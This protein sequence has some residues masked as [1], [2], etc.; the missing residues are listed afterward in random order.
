MSL[1]F[2]GRQQPQIC[3]EDGRRCV[4]SPEEKDTGST[5]YAWTLLRV[6]HPFLQAF[7]EYLRGVRRSSRH[8]TH[9]GSSSKVCK[10]KSSQV[11]KVK[12]FCCIFLQ[13][14]WVARCLKEFGDKS[15]PVTL[16]SIL[17]Q[18]WRPTSSNPDHMSCVFLWLDARGLSLTIFDSC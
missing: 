8:W 5:V 11:L 14:F 6:I 18:D 7:L 9:R 4:K 15:G 12:M 3:W 2:I 10:V 13:C 1:L 16:P 17:G